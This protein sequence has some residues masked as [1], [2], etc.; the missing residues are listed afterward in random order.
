[1]YLLKLLENAYAIPNVRLRRIILRVIRKI[2][3]GYFYKKTS[4][5]IYKK[6]YDIEIGYGSAGFIDL[7]KIAKGTVFGNYCGISKNTYIFNANHPPKYFTTNALLFNPR[8]GCTTEDVLPRTR[9]VVGHDVWI[10]LNSIILPSVN[11]IGNGAIIASGAVVTKNVDKYTIVG[12]NPAKVISNRFTPDISEKLEQSKW[13]H[14][15]KKDLIKNKERFEKIVNFSI[16]D[17]KSERASA[18]LSDH[19]SLLV[20]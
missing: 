4:R 20:P 3:G 19:T 5:H 11:S 15:S 12:G 10:G 16:D 7:D 6:Y 8:F 14:L 9:L 2:E 1:M 18:R 13:W 17:L